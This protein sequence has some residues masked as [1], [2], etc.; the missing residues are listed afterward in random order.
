MRAAVAMLLA[1]LEPASLGYDVLLLVSK[2]SVRELCLAPAPASIAG[3]GATASSA[4]LASYFRCL[5][6][7]GRK[8]RRHLKAVVSVYREA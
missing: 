4:V 5:L 1:E 2:W 6:G 3:R 7:E 8:A